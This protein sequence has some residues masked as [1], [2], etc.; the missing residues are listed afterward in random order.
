MKPKSEFPEAADWGL[1]R[2]KLARMQVPQADIPALIGKKRD[3]FTREQ[4]AI[5]I[6]N[7]ARLL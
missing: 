2:S 5:N 4:I 6:A 3:D 1:M 7:Y